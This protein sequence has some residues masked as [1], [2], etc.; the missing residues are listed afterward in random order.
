MSVIDFMIQDCVGAVQT[1]I[2][3]KEA[4]VL[5]RDLAIAIAECEEGAEIDLAIRLTSIY[6]V[7]RAAQITVAGSFG[8]IA[9]ITDGS[10]EASYKLGAA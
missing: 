10:I 4:S 6:K 5:I 3:K 9:E 8:V 2:S 1:K 7:Q